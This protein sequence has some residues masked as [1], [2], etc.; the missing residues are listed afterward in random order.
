MNNAA[1]SP[2]LDLLQHRPQHPRHP[3]MLVSVSVAAFPDVEWVFVDTPGG[4]AAPLCA[5]PAPGAACYVVLLRPE[6]RVE[7]RESRGLAKRA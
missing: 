4:Q 1:A 2:G 3:K 6:S 5:D 7:S